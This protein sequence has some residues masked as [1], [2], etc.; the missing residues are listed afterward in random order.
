VYWGPYF[1]IKFNAHRRR[2]FR[3]NVTGRQAINMRWFSTVSL[4]RPVSP[5]AFSHSTNGK[6][7]Y[8]SWKGWLKK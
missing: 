6:V 4:N 8:W 1:Q 7:L 3:A 2:N 5:L